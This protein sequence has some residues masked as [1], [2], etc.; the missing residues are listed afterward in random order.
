[1]KIKI[2]RKQNKED[3]GEKSKK[4]IKVNCGCENPNQGLKGVNFKA[5]LKI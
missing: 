1:M 4:I 2:Q 3:N 5:Q